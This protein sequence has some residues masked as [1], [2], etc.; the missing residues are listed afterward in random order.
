MHFLNGGPGFLARGH[1]PMPLS[2][3]SQVRSADQ[4]RRRAEDNTSEAADVGPTT[5]E[6]LRREQPFSRL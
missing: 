6:L 5:Q 4:L 3:G 2:P 1:R